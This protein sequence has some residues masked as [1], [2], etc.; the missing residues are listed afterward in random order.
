[1][2]LISLGGWIPYFFGIYL[3]TYRGI[4]RLLLALVDFSFGGLASAVS[5]LMVGFIVV[6]GIYRASEFV[7]MVS[8]GEIRLVES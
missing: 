6:N 8:N 3:L 4:W 7:R 1:M 5:F 2:F